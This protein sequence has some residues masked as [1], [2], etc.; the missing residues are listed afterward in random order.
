MLVIWTFDENEKQAD[1]D[2]DTSRQLE[3]VAFA[4][5]VDI[6]FQALLV[7]PEMNEKWKW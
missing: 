5:Q 2:Q 1:Q 3:S 7:D 6:Y 4:V